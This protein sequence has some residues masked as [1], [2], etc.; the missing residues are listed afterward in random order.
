MLH[1]PSVRH[2]FWWP[3][4]SDP[5]IVPYRGCIEDPGGDQ[6]LI[7]GNSGVLA[8]ERR[9]VFVPDQVPLACFSRSHGNA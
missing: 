5:R 8:V 3:H 7:V 6:V 1:H 2:A 9:D 4:L